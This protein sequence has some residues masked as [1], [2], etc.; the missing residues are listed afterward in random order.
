IGHKNTERSAYCRGVR[1]GSRPRYGLTA[2]HEHA[3]AGLR[4]EE[5]VHEGDNIVIQILWIHIGIN[6]SCWS[7]ILIRCE[8]GNASA[9]FQCLDE[10]D[11]RVQIV[12]VVVGIDVLLYDRRIRSG[13][14]DATLVSARLVD[15]ADRRPALL[16]RR[17]GH[18]AVEGL[19]SGLEVCGGGP[20]VQ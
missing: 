12:L 8:E 11:R 17:D 5:W 20:E 6:V 9:S 7:S 10:R 15:V 1:R 14:S 2:R 13:E 18:R 19:G 4:K 3:V 16:V